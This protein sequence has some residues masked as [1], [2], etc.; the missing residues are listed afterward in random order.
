MFGK[1]G[2]YLDKI[3][4]IKSGGS[5]HTYRYNYLFARWVSPRFSSIKVDRYIDIPY[6]NIT[7]MTIFAIGDEVNGERFIEFGVFGFPKTIR[8]PFTSLSANEFRFPS[9]NVDTNL[10]HVGFEVLDKC[11]YIAMPDETFRFLNQKSIKTFDSEIEATAYIS[12][13][14]SSIERKLPFKCEFCKKILWL[15]G[16]RVPD[17][18]TKAKCPV[19]QST[20]LLSKPEK[21]DFNLVRFLSSD[22]SSL[23]KEKAIVTSTGEI[24][25]VG[26][27]DVD[28]KKEEEGFVTGDDVSKDFD[29]SVQDDELN[30]TD[31]FLDEIL[32]DKFKEEKEDFEKAEAVDEVD[33]ALDVEEEVEVID[34]NRALTCPV[35][36]KPVSE[37]SAVCPSC[38]A[39]LELNVS[40][41]MGEGIDISGSSG[42]DI[43]LKDEVEEEKDI[44]DGGEVE[45]GVVEETREGESE[46][47]EEA[48]AE[49]S[50]P[51][52]KVPFW[53]EK[54]WTVK[55]EDDI[56]DNLDL[57]TLEEWVLSRSLLEEDLVRKGEEGK[58][59]K[60]KDVPYLKT[61]FKRVE[62]AL[63]LGVDVSAAAFFPARNLKR[64]I[65]F[66]IDA[67]IV[68][69][70]GGVGYFFLPKSMMNS[71]LAKMLYL[72]FLP[73]IYL[74][75]LTTE[76]GQTFGKMIL[77]LHVIDKGA[78]PPSFK[79]SLLRSLIW[80]ITFDL[81]GIFFLLGLIHPKR[82]ALHDMVAGTVVVEYE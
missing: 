57:V 17:I 80:I 3:Y 52:A 64:I 36:G 14:F 62:N 4:I 82:K 38:G 29:E 53:E 22:V 7:F 50:K 26:A 35:C 60:A 73:L 81:F 23:E 30:I 63:E 11:R 1:I 13:M 46:K 79:K 20:F 42:I 37:D 9:K 41:G 24:K 48:E 75:I 49:E 21:V 61:A 70:L 28:V 47:M 34:S 74:T 25:I 58:W 71:F 32:P 78:K 27:Q 76:R 40:D 15:Y 54:I 18:P 69:L 6:A 2:D 56:Y 67:F 19:C 51:E 31:E 8:C 66:L 72:N 68:G 59:T 55:I 45:E 77:G 10:R 12:S 39:V 5:T 65:A 44:K 33:K 43:R 16:D